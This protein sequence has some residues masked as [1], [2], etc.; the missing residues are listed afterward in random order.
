[1][2]LELHVVNPNSATNILNEELKTY[3]VDIFVS[4]DNNNLTVTTFAQLSN[5][6]LICTHS[7]FLLVW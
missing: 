7:C 1:M 2:Q 5:Q 4:T 3:E 6:Q